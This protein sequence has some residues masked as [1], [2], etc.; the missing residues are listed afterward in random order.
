MPLYLITEANDL[1]SWPPFHYAA[2]AM[3]A[4]VGL[5][6]FPPGLVMFSVCFVVGFI[7][8]DRANN[9]KTNVGTGG[10]VPSGMLFH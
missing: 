10:N 8:K 6:E 1:I 5:S 9:P 4:I 7:F 2:V 3:E